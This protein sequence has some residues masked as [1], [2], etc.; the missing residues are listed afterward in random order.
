[1][2]E[3]TVTTTSDD[4]K[5][6]LPYTNVSSSGSKN[7]KVDD[8]K[9]K[10]SSFKLD[11]EPIDS[12]IQPK[13]SPDTKNLIGFL[14]GSTPIH[15]SPATDL[16]KLFPGTFLVTGSAKNTPTTPPGVSFLLQNNDVTDESKEFAE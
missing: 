8:I 14:N 7:S 12:Q 6:Y 3:I 1:M 9:L 2:P 13:M 15:V 10:K 5:I 11:L 16:E 4:G